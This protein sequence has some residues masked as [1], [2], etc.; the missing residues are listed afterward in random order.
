MLAAAGES[1]G[2]S[3]AAGE[4]L[5]PSCPFL[6]LPWLSAA[7]P[8][9]GFVGT[10]LSSWLT[11]VA[12]LP[13]SL[14]LFLSFWCCAPRRVP[15]V[16]WWA[17]S[18]EDVSVVWAVGL[19]RGDN[20]PVPA[21]L[22]CVNRSRCW[23]QHG[24]WLGPQSAE[25]CLRARSGLERGTPPGVLVLC[26]GCGGAGQCAACTRST[27]PVWEHHSPSVFLAGRRTGPVEEEEGAP[28]AEDALR[29]SWDRAVAQAAYLSLSPLLVSVRCLSNA[30]PQRPKHPLFVPAVVLGSWERQD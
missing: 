6:S 1:V 20:T 19:S 8:W 14:S 27:P 28:Q 22:R 15:L 21:R 11:L 17:R 25:S 13:R 9:A 30:S 4:A 24:L 3:R 18:Q 10:F 23:W 16:L 29:R 5:G 26:F 7:S 2:L 12:S